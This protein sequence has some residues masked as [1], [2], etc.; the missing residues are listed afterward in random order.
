[1]WLDRCQFSAWLLITPS[2]IVA[3]QVITAPG[4]TEYEA[5]VNLSRQLGNQQSGPV[6]CEPQYQLNPATNQ[7][8]IWQYLCKT[9]LP[10]PASH[11][12]T[13]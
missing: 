1:M 9:T 2:L 5:R 13:K 4:P 11:S 12:I 3:Q 8:K 6:Y 7:Y 10:D